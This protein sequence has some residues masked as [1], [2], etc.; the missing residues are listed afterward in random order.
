MA[1]Q[2]ASKLQRLRHARAFSVL[3]AEVIAA[4]GEERQWRVTIRRDGVVEQLGVSAVVNC[5]GPTCDID[6]YPHDL[7]RRL[8][9]SGL[10]TP[11][12]L[13]LGVDTTGRGHVVDRMGRADARLTAIGPLRRGGLY[14]STAVPELRAQA[15]EIAAGIVQLSGRQRVLSG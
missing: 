8:V 15:A 11:D 6:R 9:T 4:T 2:V 5:T 13:G 14:E 3:R 12:P 7:G 10:V 1:P